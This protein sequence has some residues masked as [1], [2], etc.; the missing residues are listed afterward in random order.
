MSAIRSQNI[1]TLVTFFFVYVLF[2]SDTCMENYEGHL[3]KDIGKLH[4]SWGS[5]HELFNAVPRGC[6]LLNT[7]AKQAGLAKV[8]Q[9]SKH[10]FYE[11]MKEAQN[12]INVWLNVDLEHLPGTCATEQ[13]LKE[14]RS[15]HDT[16]S[17]F[18]S[19]TIMVF[20]GV[21]LLLCMEQFGIT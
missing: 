8:L 17:L 21:E 11:S 16:T 5:G 9:A 3:A 14:S 10:Y 13:F 2:M 20:L 6:H 7:A 15:T 4:I 1:G 18:V 19:C 12:S